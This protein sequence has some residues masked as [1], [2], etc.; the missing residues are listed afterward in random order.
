MDIV[1]EVYG[2]YRQ[3]LEETM[4]GLCQRGQAVSES[5]PQVV[6]DMKQQCRPQMQDFV[7]TVKDT[8]DVTTPQKAVVEIF[9]WATVMVFFANVGLE[10][11]C[12]I[13]APIATLFVGKVGAALAAFIIVPFYAH[14]QIKH[15]LDN[16]VI[17]RFEM[18]PMAIL[19]GILT[20][21]AISSY[22]ITDIPFAVLT[23]A[24]ITV[25]YPT[26]ANSAD[27]NRVK[28][29][30]GSVATAVGV[31]FLLGLTTESL[32]FCYLLLTTFYAA[33]CAL[34]MQFVFRNVDIE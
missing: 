15:S 5:L 27:G 21:L 24:T 26:I 19:Q 18:L 14:Y 8:S 29:L 17:I 31:N 33:I 2:S 22:T 20:G 1:A 32:T 12:Y 28:L 34:A 13:L 25:A 30:G 4:E 9:A 6:E 11:G 7:E 16:D 23:P 3:E 10:F